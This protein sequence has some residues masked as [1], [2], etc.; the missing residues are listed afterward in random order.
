[1][2]LGAVDRR[3]VKTLFSE[4]LL[5]LA[6]WDSELFDVEVFDD[7]TLFCNCCCDWALVVTILLTLLPDIEPSEAAEAETEGRL[8]AAAL[9]RP[10]PDFEQEVGFE[11]KS[12]VNSGWLSIIE[13]LLLF[14]SSVLSLSLFGRLRFLL[15]CQVQSLLVLITPNLYVNLYKSFFTKVWFYKL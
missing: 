15:L 9:E 10:P 4:F 8:A 6:L 13:E 3:L 11:V 7:G 1:M 5:L 12:D 14:S 2:G